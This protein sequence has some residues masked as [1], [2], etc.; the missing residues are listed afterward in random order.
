ML[1]LTLRC[2]P[3]HTSGALVYSQINDWSYAQSFYYAANVGYSIGFGALYEYNEW[4]LA[5]SLVMIVLGSSVIGGAIGYF[6]SMAIDSAGYFKE[7]DGD[8]DE[9]EGFLSCFKSLRAYYAKTPSSSRCSPC[10]SA[11]SLSAPPV[12]LRLYRTPEIDL[13]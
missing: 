12:R 11:G 10:S 1:V 13:S 3:C 6:A 5:F 8:N 9:A 2:N 7:D 4:S